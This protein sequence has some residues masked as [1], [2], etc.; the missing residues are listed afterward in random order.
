[1]FRI[2]LFLPSVCRSRCVLHAPLLIF[3]LH[4]LPWWRSTPDSV[5]IIMP[6][7]ET[8]LAKLIAKVGSP[9]RRTSQIFPYQH[10]CFPA[11]W[12]Y[13]CTVLVHAQL[14][15]TKLPRLPLFIEYRSG[16]LINPHRSA[17]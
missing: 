1:M 11:C 6:M 13:F 3:D 9:L 12:D 15:S 10:S 8:D 16:W 17:I 2:W 5:F 4:G 7:I 14:W